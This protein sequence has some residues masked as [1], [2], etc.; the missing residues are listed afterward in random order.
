MRALFDQGVPAPLR[1]H[2]AGHDV[3]TSYECG[4]SMLKNGELLDRAEREGFE[5][6]VTTD[7]NPRHQ[8]YLPARRI[9]I[10]VLMTTSWPRMQRVLDTI[11]RAIDGATVP[12]CVDVPIL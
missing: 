3:S 10:V 8:Q 2:L 4:W 12:G 5:V 9:S 11:L 7:T 6:F 1:R